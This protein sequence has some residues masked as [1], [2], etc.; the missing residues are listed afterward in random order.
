MAVAG[1]HGNSRLSDHSSQCG[2]S[3]GHAWFANAAGRQVSD[4][5]PKVT[6][7]AQQNS[8]LSLNLPFHSVKSKARRRAVGHGATMPEKQV[9]S[10]DD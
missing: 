7:W 5:L 3:P 1:H 6:L 4:S 10:H 8:N 2:R 9:Y